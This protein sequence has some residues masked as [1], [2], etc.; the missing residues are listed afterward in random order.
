MANKTME[1][2]SAL[3]KSETTRNNLRPGM[4]SIPEISMTL[5]TI[6]QIGKMYDALRATNE[7]VNPHET[8][9]AR[10]MRYEK[11][12]QTT[13]AK[14]RDITEV[15]AAKL[16]MLAKS[17]ETRA[18]EQAGLT[19]GP[20]TG[21]EIRSA[22]RQMPQADRDKAIAD[23]FERGDNEVLSSI[24]GHNRVTWGGTSKP[25]DRQ[26]QQYIDRNA[27]DAVKLREAID[28]ATEG[29][30]FAA[31]S[32]VSSATKWRDPLTAAKG[33]AQEKEYE[34]ADAALKAALGE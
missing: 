6:D 18:L 8:I 10:A 2:R 17:N 19:S 9:E 4:D 15:A 13:V 33:F 28:K 16:D 1:I 22:L 5:A 26:F 29:L 11:Q 32:F 7:A 24:Y 30:G 12:F 14:A 20:P 21:P 34:Q 23:A 27:P 25:L 3:I 31:D